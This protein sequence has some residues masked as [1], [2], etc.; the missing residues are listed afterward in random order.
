MKTKTVYHITNRDGKKISTTT[1][2]RRCS[3]KQGYWW[4]RL[5][6]DTFVSLGDDYPGNCD[7][8]AMVQLDIEKPT[9][10]VLGCGPSG[11][12]GRFCVRQRGCLVPGETE[13]K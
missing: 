6:D 11:N 5:E 9:K 2:W 13:V 8:D 12:A 1:L 3:G 4:L 7:L 10:Y